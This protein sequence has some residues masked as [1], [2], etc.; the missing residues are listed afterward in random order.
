MIAKSRECLL[1][2]KKTLTKKSQDFEDLQTSSSLGRLKRVSWFC[3]FK[4]NLSSHFTF[5]S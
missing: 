4:Q 1:F 5:W 2:E 3:L